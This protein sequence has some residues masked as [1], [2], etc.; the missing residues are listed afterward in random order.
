[1]G[2]PRP[3]PC[4]LDGM[5]SIGAFGGKKRWRSQDGKRLYE[6]DDLHGEIEGYNKR[7]KHIGVFH[8]ITGAL[9]KPAVRGRTI[10]V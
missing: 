1:M 10:D 9:I 7:G 3:S 4:F 5:V 6:W 8:V 2:V